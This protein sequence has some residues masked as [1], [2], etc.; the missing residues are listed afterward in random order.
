MIEQKIKAQ[1]KKNNNYKIRPTPYPPCPHPDTNQQ[2]LAYPI[3]RINYNSNAMDI[4][5]LVQM[6]QSNKC[7]SVRNDV[8]LNLHLGSMTGL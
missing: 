2:L 1:I 5:S 3:Q 6:R 7:A 8:I 4:E